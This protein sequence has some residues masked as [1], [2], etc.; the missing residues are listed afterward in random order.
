MSEL[1]VLSAIDSL[2]AWRA[3]AG[4]QNLRVGLVPTMGNLHAGHISLVKSA[5]ANCD[6]VLAT[7]FVNPM[8]FGPNEDLARYPR[9]FEADCAA[10]TDAGCT[11][12]FAPEAAALYPRGVQTQ[13]R[14]SVPN[15]GDLHCGKSRPGHF[16][17]VTTIV[18][19]LF[20]LTQAHDAYFGLKDFQQFRVIS[21]MVEDLNINIHLHGVPIVRESDGLAMSSRNGYL[22]D[23]E[24]AKAPH[25]HTVLQLTAAKVAGGAVDFRSLEH[26]AA[27]VLLAAGFKPDYIAIC[28][29]D[30]LQP[31]EDDSKP[32]A[33]LAAAYLGNTRLID[34]ILL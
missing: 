3:E 1:V 31:A 7:L 9:T 19:K 11:A 6:V 17:G 13:T 8:Q 33:L 22:S 30:T 25:L 2:R 32:L 20:N 24:R 29:Q 16:D 27:A 15:L 34:N 12:L 26:E 10:L 21:T 4:R 18:T 23:E 14:I 28:Y 5:K